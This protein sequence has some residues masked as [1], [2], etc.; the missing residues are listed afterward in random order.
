MIRSSRYLNR[1]GIFASIAVAILTVSSCRSKGSDAESY[2]YAAP[3]SVIYSPENA[4]GFI[5]EGWKGR[6]SLLITVSR[7]WQGADSVGSSA[8]TLLILRNGEDIPAG[9]QGS[10]IKDEARKIITMSSTHIA[11]LE[12][13]DGTD[14]IAGVSGLRFVSSPA[15]AA[16]AEGVVDVGYDGNINYENLAG[17]MPDLVLL[18]GV[19]GPSAMEGK[20]RELDIPYIYISDYMEEHPLGKAEWAVALGEI[21]GRREAARNMYDSIPERYHS[22]AGMVR[23][24]VSSC[25]GVMLNT[26]YGGTWWMPP[27]DSYMVRLITDAGGNY[28]YRGKMTHQS[29][30]IDIEEATSMVES[31]D[32]WLNPGTLTSA[33][34]LSQQFPRLKNAQCVT[35]GR[36]WN[37]NRRS[38]RGGGNDFYESGIMHPDVILADLISI[39]HPELMAGY[40]PFYYTRLQ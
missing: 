23:E 27:S 2:T 3:D 18:Y 11:M 33:G 30:P 14:R 7:P 40:E 31:A 36:V 20:L 4:S 13:L 15:I 17:A 39:F 9:Y 1:L 28:L 10:V 25:P 37:N 35:S 8:S 34:S 21:I 32:F 38:T 26:P 6:R 19:S 16:R 12:A 5:I 22:L 29:T 24:R